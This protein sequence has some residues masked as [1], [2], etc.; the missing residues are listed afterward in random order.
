MDF[1]QNVAF[2]EKIDKCV[3]D[4]KKD[5]K[6][7]KNDI[8][9]IVL[10]VTELIM[11]SNTVSKIAPTTEQL[12]ASIDH[13]YTYIMSHYNLF[14]EDELQKVAFKI[15]FDTCV[16]LALFQPTINKGTKSLFAC[17]GRGN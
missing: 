2:I 1:S 15:M 3:K 9:V 5:G 12:A 11:T 14:P 4:V 8:P 7:D 17:I 16:K 6:L 13:L 10:L